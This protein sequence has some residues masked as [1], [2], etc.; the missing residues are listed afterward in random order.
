MSYRANVTVCSEI[1]TNHIDIVWTEST[2]FNAKPVSAAS[3]QWIL[4]GHFNFR[5]QPNTLK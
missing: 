1:N 5:T 3:N 2:I 4:K